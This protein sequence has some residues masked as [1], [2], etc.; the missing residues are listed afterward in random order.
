MRLSG[1]IGRRDNMWGIWCH[2]WIGLGGG[3]GGGGEW[4]ETELG[5]SKRKR[6]MDCNGG[7]R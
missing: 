4:G 2:G 3:G 5:E 7:V 6:G 1:W